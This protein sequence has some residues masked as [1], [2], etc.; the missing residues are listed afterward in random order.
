MPNLTNA[1]V[2]QS[3][4][5]VTVNSQP[6]TTKVTLSNPDGTVVSIQPDGTRQTRVAGTAGPW[7]LCDLQGALAVYNPVPGVVWF[8]GFSN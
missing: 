6:N 5:P 8:Y 3:S 4:S 2:A 1:P 7:E